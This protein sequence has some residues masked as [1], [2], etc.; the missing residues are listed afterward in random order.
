MSDEWKLCNKGME[1]YQRY[2]DLADSDLSD[3]TVIGTA[4]NEWVQHKMYC[5]ECG[6]SK[7]KHDVSK[8]RTKK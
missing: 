3:E 2:C 1:L 5:P 7:Y 4:W 6:G 8:E